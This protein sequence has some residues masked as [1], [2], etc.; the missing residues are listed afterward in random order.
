MDGWIFGDKFG[1][2]IKVEFRQF[3]STHRFLPCPASPST[4]MNIQ[5]NIGPG[6]IV[7]NRAK[8]IIWASLSREDFFIR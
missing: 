4:M 1:R 3:Q 8:Y 7:G 5:M 6:Q 2:K